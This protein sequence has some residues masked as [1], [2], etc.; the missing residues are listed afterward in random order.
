MSTA[1]YDPLDFTP[2]QIKL[3]TDTVAKGATK[4]ELALFL[5][6]AKSLGLDPLKPGQIYFIKYGNSSGC[7]VIGLDGFRSRAQRTG[8]LAGI[9]RGAIRNDKGL[10]VGA[11]AEVY[12]SD[13]KECAREEVPLNEYDTNKG[14][15]A[16]LKETMIKKVAECAALRM[17][18]PD[19]LGGLY[20]QE[21][22]DQTGKGRI[23]CEQ[24]EEGDAIPDPVWRMPKGSSK[25][26]TLDQIERKDLEHQLLLIEEREAKTG[27][28]T[29]PA[30]VEV[31]DTI[32]E[33]LI[34][35]DNELVD[36]M[37]K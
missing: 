35:Q 30:W 21:E 15:W 25:G 17:A 27:P 22:M 23:V 14:S 13:W 18:F 29:D 4:D 36:R 7:I 28:L 11:W 9:K 8:K 5:Y 37:Q 33:Y 24:P 26:K 19:D 32:K 3:I 34:A 31:R 6:R 2:E 12:R 16:R 20:S 1:L 10:L